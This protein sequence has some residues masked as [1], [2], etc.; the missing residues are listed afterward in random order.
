MS[1]LWYKEKNG[2][3]FITEFVFPCGSAQARYQRHDIYTSSV[4]AAAL[5]PLRAQTQA[6]GGGGAV[7]ATQIGHRK[8]HYHWHL[9]FQRVENSW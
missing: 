1:L 6:G 2:M 9:I 4:Q 7:V 3:E 5:S 8:Q